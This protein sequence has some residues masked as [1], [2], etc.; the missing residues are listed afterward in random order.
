[1][2]QKSVSGSASIIVLGAPRAGARFVGEAELEAATLALSV[3]PFALVSAKV[4]A[5]AP[6]WE[7]RPAWTL[8]A[9]RSSR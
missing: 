2:S 8:G 7:I 5:I 1:M 4:R 9:E 6:H 3:E